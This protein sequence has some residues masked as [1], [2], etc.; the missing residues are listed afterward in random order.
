MRNRKSL[1]I[2]IVLALI[3][4]VMTYAFAAAINPGVTY[5]ASGN[6]DVP[7]ITV[8]N[9]HYELDSTDPT[10]IAYVELKLGVIIP[11]TG[12]VKVALVETP[13]TANWI[14]CT[15]VAGAG[16]ADDDFRCTPGS[17]VA[18]TSITQ[19]HVVAAQ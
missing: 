18:V 2:F 3:L 15:P 4:A 8:S 1:P 14:T 12:E 10:N 19:L 9:I 6:G 16:S 7:D 11:A 5:A 17:A 13:A